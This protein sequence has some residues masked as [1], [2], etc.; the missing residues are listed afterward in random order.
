MIILYQLKNEYFLG[1]EDPNSLS[2]KRSE[3]RLYCDLLMQQ[4]HAVKS[5]ATTEGGPELQVWYHY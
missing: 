4:V 3:L 2:H 1:L 5:A